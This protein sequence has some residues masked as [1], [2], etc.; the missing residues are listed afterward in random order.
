MER[1]K[2]LL[3]KRSPETYLMCMSSFNS[4]ALCAKVCTTST[5][6][7]L[8]AFLQP[9]MWSH[10][11]PG[12]CSAQL[13]LSQILVGY[14]MGFEKLS[15]YILGL[16]EWFQLC[17]RECNSS[18][19]FGSVTYNMSSLP[20]HIIYLVQ[21]KTTIGPYCSTNMVHISSLLCQ[22]LME[23]VVR[24]VHEFRLAR[25]LPSKGETHFQPR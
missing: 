11:C 13:M 7:A 14:V 20:H 19:R 6:L 24:E 9:Q 10:R 4:D 1:N 15:G 16:V 21:V 8:V 3:Y 18:G 25:A 12:R 17:V 2:C 22:L 23:V 5:F